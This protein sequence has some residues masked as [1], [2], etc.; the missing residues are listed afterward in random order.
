MDSKTRRTIAQ[1]LR[2]AAHSLSAA[3]LATKGTRVTGTFYGDDQGLWEYTEGYPLNILKMGWSWEGS[4][5]MSSENQWRNLSVTGATEHSR[6]FRKALKE[7]VK[8]Y[9]EVRDFLISFDG[10][11]KE[12]S[13]LVDGE[14]EADL[15]K[16]TFYHGT[17]STLLDVIQAEG[18]KPRSITK[19][20]PSFG[21][22][23][24]APDGRDDAIYLTTQMGMARAAAFSATKNEVRRKETPGKPVIFV[25]SGLNP[26]Y[27]VADEDSGE[28]DPVKSLE[29]IGSIAYTRPIHP[30]L[31]K[32]VLKV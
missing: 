25:V 20:D 18:L 14:E 1:A 15:S 32:K 13:D 27:L 6:G 10:P 19:R 5:A 7:I 2:E 23:F 22:E 31:I 24:R 11:Y 30:R 4:I 29:R 28:T 3:K 12:V 21:S 17:T 8:E 26:R 16:V 9:P